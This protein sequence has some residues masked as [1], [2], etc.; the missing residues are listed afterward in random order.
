MGWALSGRLALNRT[1]DRILG[2][3]R[4]ASMT[5]YSTTRRGVMGVPTERES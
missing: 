2:Q 3:E 1:L 4:E 5:L